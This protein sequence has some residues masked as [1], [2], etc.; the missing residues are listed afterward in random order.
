[1]LSMK[2]VKKLKTEKIYD[3][4]YHNMKTSKDLLT[5]LRVAQKSESF[6]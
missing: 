5:N 4:L 1:M 6:G 3:F 2:I